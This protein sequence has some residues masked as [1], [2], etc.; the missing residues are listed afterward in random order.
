MDYASHSNYPGGAPENSAEAGMRIDLLKGL[1]P[2]KEVWVAEFQ[3]GPLH[4]GI[5]IEAEVNK[6]FSHACKALYFCRREP[7][8]SGPSLGSTA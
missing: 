1:A 5:H 4:R 7:L 2:D 8:M 3:G 6:I